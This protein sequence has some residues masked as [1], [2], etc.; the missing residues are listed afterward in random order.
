MN[1]IKF[2]QFLKKNNIKFLL[3][4]NDIFNKN[5]DLDLYI[6][7]NYKKKLEK[8][9]YKKNFFRRKKEVLGYPNRFFYYDELNKSKLILDISFKI[10]FFK[11]KFLYYQLKE[12]FLNESKENL[13][14]IIKIAR[15]FFYK[16]G[17]LKSINSF[18][19]SKKNSYIRKKFEINKK[20]EDFISL[21]KFILPFFVIN[22]KFKFFNKFRFKSNYILFLGS[23]GSGKTTLANELKNQLVSKV[24]LISF[25]SSEKYWLSKILF[26]LA[27]KYKKNKKTYSIFFFIDII[28]RRIKLFFFSNHHFIFIDRFPGF[29]FNSNFKSKIFSIVLPKPNLIFL[30]KTQKKIIKERKPLEF[31][32][33]YLKWINIGKSLGINPYIIDTSRLSISKTVFKVKKIIFSKKKFFYNILEN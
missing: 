13:L 23:D 8:L 17:N 7:I 16:K 5:K 4:S 21:K 26:F 10:I 32:N 25:G 18:I 19:F 1:K 9:I 15:M 33:D 20:F 31:K 28:L 27:G 2:V 11:N 24:Y 3:L 6:N 14:F 30:L 12:S 22:F 29:I